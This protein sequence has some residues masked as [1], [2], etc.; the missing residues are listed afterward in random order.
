MTF[1]VLFSRIEQREK[2]AIQ[3][4]GEIGAFGPVAF[5]AGVTEQIRIIAAPVFFGDDMLDVESEE[6]CI[7]FVQAAVFTA[8]AC[9]LPDE[10]PEGGIHHSPAEL[11][12]S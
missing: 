5:R 11:A 7:V 9:P 10:G 3:K 8:T 2:P 6:V 1:P 4:A 12:S